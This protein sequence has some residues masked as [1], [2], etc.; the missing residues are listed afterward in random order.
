[1]LSSH[2]INDS[3]FL[4][5]QPIQCNTAKHVEVDI[6][7]IIII[8]CSG[9]MSWDLP[10]IREQLKKKLPKLLGI[11]DT[12]S[13]IWFSGRGEFGTLLEA[14]KV[15]SLTDLTT[16]NNT[17]DRWLKPIGLTGFKEPL[18]EVSHLIDRIKNNNV[19][20]LFFMSD[21]CDNQWNKS[22]IIRA[23]ELSSGNLAAATFVE[24]GY[25]AD[26]PLLTTMAEKAGGALIFSDSFDKYSPIFETV[27][28]KKLSGAPRIN[29]TIS[30]VP[31]GGFVFAL[32]DS[33][34]LTFGVTEGTANVPEIQQIYYLSSSPL[35]DIETDVK[36]ISKKT[37]ATKPQLNVLKH[38][39]AATSL[40]SI[41]MKSEIVYPLL[42]ALGDVKLINQFSNCFGKQKY[43][44]F[45]EDTK[46]AAWDSSE[47]LLQGWNPDVVPPEDAFTILD[48]LDVLTKDDANKV[49]IDTPLFKYNRIGR[50]VIDAGSKLTKEEQIEIKDLTEEMLSS[51][52]EDATKIIA[53]VGKILND[54]KPPL[55][56]AARAENK[57][58]GYSISNLTLNEDRP[59][60][61]IQINKKGRVDLSSR[62]PEEFKRIPT[63][64]ETHIFRNYS[65]IADGIVN[66]DV[67]PV[68]LTKATFEELNKANIIDKQTIQLY[69]DDVYLIN[70]KKLPIVNRKMVKSVSARELFE[71]CY[72]LTKARA[73]QKVYNTYKKETCEKKTLKG[74]VELYGEEAAKWLEEQG[75]SYNGF[76][77]KTTLDVIKDF[78]MGKELKV[79]LAKLST[80]P[81]VNDVQKQ[82][83]KGKLTT[84]G[85]LMAPHIA[86]IEWFLA[87]EVYTNSSD[88]NRLLE[89]WLDSELKSNQK[90]VRRLLYE[91]AK[92][93]FS[94]I[95][96]Q[97]WFNEFNSLDETEL[98]I[99]VDQNTIKCSVEMREI[100]VKI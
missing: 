20:N 90:T 38:V 16:V 95:V 65:I 68:R 98:E 96:G 55:K 3:L 49:L 32:D 84:S 61:S 11:N 21:G 9:S 64:F 83:K 37:N 56:F 93:K 62:L 39:Y 23:I 80:L 69:E 42:Q 50:S 73:A 12:V 51:S 26:R 59:N 13:I 89:T 48:L 72:E 70:L 19:F 92:I 10:K 30:G 100:E 97:V 57:D 8:D 18:E 86:T 7:H 63:E 60:I 74:F 81:S 78:Y 66:V 14:E 15:A 99:M 79:S 44:E 28:Q 88:R 34:I 36:N 91:I 22:E 77:P 54:R 35:G 1:M 17:I 6:N 33:D 43:S 45:M 24:Y 67:L 87:S 47:R 31:I 27:I 53:K 40:F 82:L 85:E 46:K 58:L 52:I 76:A 5:Q 29:V 71:K 94:V 2:K 25:Y 75:F 4:I 41:R